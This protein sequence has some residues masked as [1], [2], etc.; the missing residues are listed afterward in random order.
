[1]LGDCGREGT[2]CVYLF[3]ITTVMGLAP[4]KNSSKEP[5]V[6]P[7]DV[8]VITLGCGCHSHPIIHTRVTSRSRVG[9]VWW[10]TQSHTDQ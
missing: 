10:L 3:V 2:G 6:G 9:V 8:I 7:F 4:N 5:L 1:M